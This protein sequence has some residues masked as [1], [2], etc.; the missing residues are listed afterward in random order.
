MSL[1]CPD[2]RGARPAQAAP[3]PLGLVGRR[4]AGDRRADLEGDH[5]TGRCGRS[6][7]RR[8]P[9]RARRGGRQQR[10]ARLPRGA[11]G[12]ARAGGLHRQLRRREPRA[13]QAGRRRR[14]CSRSLAS[15]ATWFVAIGIIGALGGPGLDVQAGDGPARGGCAPRR[16]ELVLPQDLL[17]GLD[18]GP[19]PPPAHAARAA[20][21]ATCAARARAPRLHRRLSRRLR[22]RALPAEPACHGRLDDRARRRR[23]RAARSR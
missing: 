5:R 12:G 8:H 21:P 13:P 2:R 20:E 6:D 14:R 7:R 4:G 18:L 16:H 23:P 9:P 22:G 17:D 15:V 1:R 11:R 3:A 19:Q 10:A